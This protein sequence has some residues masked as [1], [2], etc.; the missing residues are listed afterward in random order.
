MSYVLK[1]M[2]VRE[3]LLPVLLKILVII[4]KNKKQKKGNQENF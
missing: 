4:F 3:F 1:K 2:K